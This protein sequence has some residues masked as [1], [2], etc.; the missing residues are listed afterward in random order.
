MLP[1]QELSVV[2]YLPE[3][4]SSRKR[5]LLY[6]HLQLSNSVDDADW[7]SDP[8]MPVIC[9]SCWLL[10]CG[11][12]DS[13][14]V[15]RTDSQLL[16]MPPYGDWD[17]FDS[18]SDSLIIKISEWQRVQEECPSLP[19]VGEFPQITNHD[20]VQLWLQERPAVAI[21]GEEQELELHLRK[22]C[23]ASHPFE[24]D[25]AIEVI[26]GHLGVLDQPPVELFGTFQEVATDPELFNSFF[27]DGDESPEFAAFSTD[28]ANRLLIAN[29]LVFG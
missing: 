10:S 12:K 6:G 11:R 13:A 22:S 24:L 7:R 26:R 15:V 17:P 28:S 4:L 20:V 5:R 29:R 16:W 27:F 8:V 19:D 9:E 18:I 3:R 2:S 1:A 25:N 21:P 23:V 14:H